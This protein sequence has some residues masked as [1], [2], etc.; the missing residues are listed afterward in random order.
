MW[1]MKKRE[2]ETKM[3]PKILNVTTRRTIGGFCAEI[4]LEEKKNQSF[5]FWHVMFG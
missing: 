5:E 3:S 1:D 2:R 4:V